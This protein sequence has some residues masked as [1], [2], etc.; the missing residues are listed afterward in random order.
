[1]KAKNNKPSISP[2]ACPSPAEVNAAFTA[3]SLNVFGLLDALPFYAMLV[4]S[5]H[6][7]IMA[8]KAIQQFLGV[9]PEDIQG[10]FCPKAIHGVDGLFPG[11]PLEESVEKGHGVECEIK[12]DKTGR[13]V[14]SSIYPT[15][16]MTPQGKEIFFHM[17]TD[18]TD[19]KQAEE[20]LKASRAQLRRLSAHLESMK[21][22]ERDR[23]AHD[24]HDD[25][26]QS[27]SAL[28]AY[29]EAAL[30]QLP[31]D[32]E[33]SRAMLEKSREVSRRILDDLH[34]LIYDLH[35]VSLRDFGIFPAASSLITT[36]LEP[37]GIKVTLKAIGRAK[38]FAPDLELI[39]FRVIQ[40]VFSN[41]T[42]HARAKNVGVT[43]QFKKTIV[44]LRVI[45]DGQG[46]DVDEAG[47]TT[48]GLRGFG[49]MSIRERIE[50]AGGTV[51]IKS[52]LNEGTKINIEIP[53]TYT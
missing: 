8:N 20:R 9:S 21:E 11:C 26:S 24:L 40:E 10:Q 32:A 19:R 15:G 25:T 27:V 34:K 30:M 47:K 45:D 29:L 5:S 36:S 48:S 37:A 28:T 41:I 43:I 4:D 12:D 13:W 23:I 2:V 51:T 52:R 33:D 22:E 39:L 6:H 44:I 49:L 50:I 38:R 53:V 1:M 42:R 7:I 31:A 16:A 17:V 35:P 46:F 18:I 3:A 14:R